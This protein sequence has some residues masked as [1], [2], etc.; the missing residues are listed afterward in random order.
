MTDSRYLPLD[1]IGGKKFKIEIDPP[2]FG[3]KKFNAW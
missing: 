2:D 1:R 3:G